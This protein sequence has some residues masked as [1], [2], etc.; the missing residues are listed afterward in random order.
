MKKFLLV[1]IMMMCVVFL[2][3]CGSET[4][5]PTSNSPASTYNPTY[6]S[7]NSSKSNNVGAVSGIQSSTSNVC[8]H[9]G[10]TNKVASGDTVY[11]SMHSNK[12]LNC[13]KYIDEDALYCMSCLKDSVSSKNSKNNYSSSYSSS[14]SNEKGYYGSDGY[15]NPTDEELEQALKDAEEWLKDNY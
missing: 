4:Y 3:S 12:C 9:S 10:C 5:E 11:C 1:T 13:G 8:A 6:Q 2:N 7:S 14:Y 15:Y